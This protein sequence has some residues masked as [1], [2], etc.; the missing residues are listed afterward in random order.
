MQDV[1]QSLQEY[2]LDP[3]A[4]E[5][6]VTES[7]VME[8]PERFIGVL[9]ELHCLG[10]PIA[11][12]DFG[13]GYSSLSFIKRF[14]IDVL[15][16]DKS[17]VRDIGTDPSDAAICQT[18]IDMAHNLGLSVVAEGVETAEQAAFLLGYGCDV[19]QGYLFSKL[20]PPETDFA[21]NIKKHEAL[22]AGLKAAGSVVNFSKN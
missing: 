7:V 9:S 16:I 1:R 14:P 18:I 20:L 21:A 10:V 19:F 8:S 6:E 17:F 12:D 2:R 15:K 22:G 11:V 13:T 3:A 5:L 4:L